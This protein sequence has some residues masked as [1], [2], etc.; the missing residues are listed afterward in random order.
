[1]MQKSFQRV[2]KVIF[3]TNTLDMAVMVSI[4]LYK[5]NAL[6]PHDYFMQILYCVKI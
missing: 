3:G 4:S 2:L 1:L 5:T 6:W